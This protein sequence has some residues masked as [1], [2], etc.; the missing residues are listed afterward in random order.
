MKKLFVYYGRAPRKELS[1]RDVFVKCCKD[2]VRVN[3]VYDVPC[4]L[5]S[6]YVKVKHLIANIKVDSAELNDLNKF[7]ASPCFL[8][9]SRESKDRMYDRNV[10]LT[11]RLQKY[12]Q[13]IEE[14]GFKLEPGDLA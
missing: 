11:R 3:S 10:L 5:R 6:A 9:E 1:V 14:L 12:G 4:H 2:V 13:E 7:M 8:N